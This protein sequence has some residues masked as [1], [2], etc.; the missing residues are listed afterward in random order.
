VTTFEP[1]RAPGAE[2]TEVSSWLPP[3]FKTPE[4][5]VQSWRDGQVKITQTTQ[6]LAEQE[7]QLE[8][9]FASQEQDEQFAEPR[10]EQG[11][12][13]QLLT[14]Q[15]LAQEAA[16]RGARSVVRS[17]ATGRVEAPQDPQALSR[18]MSETMPQRDPRWNETDPD[19]LAQIIAEKPDLIS[20]LG[21]L[22]SVVSGLSN[23]A[24]LA[25]GRQAERTMAA[26]SSAEE[27]RQAKLSA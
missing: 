14:M 8:A 1:E 11:R 12:E 27:T 19:L 16:T 17:L 23:A 20:D 4:A 21:D 9:F 24:A 7:Q 18:L 2:D 22:N 15:R 25:R 26:W 13:Q 5:L 10:R 3:N 6:Q